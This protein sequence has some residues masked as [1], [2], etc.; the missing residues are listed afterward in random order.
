MARFVWTAGAGWTAVILSLILIALPY[1]FRRH[2][3][4]AGAQPMVHLRRLRPHFWLAYLLVGLSLVH[5]YLVMGPAMVRADRIGV[6]AAT[7]AFCVLFLQVLL[8]L[9]LQ[10]QAISLRRTVQRW[11]FVGML[12]FAAMVAAH[13][14]RNG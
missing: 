14:W 2:P 7:L 3:I 10:T 1:W 11:H 13:V 9:Y 6:F 12:C 4:R 8:G 5:A